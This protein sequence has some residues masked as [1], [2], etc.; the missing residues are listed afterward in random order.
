MD[1][2]AYLKRVVELTKNVKKPET[3]SSYPASINSPSRRAL[4][5]NL[6]DV[7]RLAD[8]ITPENWAADEHRDIAEVA[9]LA[10]D[11][12]VQ[13]VK[14]AG[15]RGNR[16][17]EREVLGAIKSVLRD[18]ELASQIFEIAKNQRDY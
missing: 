9:A 14:K 11:D 18:E 3:G 5:D 10:V 2:K 13:K 1:Y 15:W 16:F 12:T 6:K 8:L 4:Y 7:H 17:K